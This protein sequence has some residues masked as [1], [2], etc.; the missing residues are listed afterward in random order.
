MQHKFKVAKKK[1]IWEQTH[2]I[3][4]NNIKSTNCISLQWLYSNVWNTFVK[5]S[6]MYSSL[7]I[8][9]VDSVK[10]IDWIYT[11]SNKQHHIKSKYEIKNTNAPRENQNKQ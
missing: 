11:R 4:I 3:Q 10:V 8:Y 9:K 6:V 1:W 5:K 7:W 2:N